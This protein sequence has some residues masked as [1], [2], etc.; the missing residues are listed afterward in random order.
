MGRYGSYATQT[1]AFC[2]TDYEPCRDGSESCSKTCSNRLKTLRKYGVVFTSV[3]DRHL[4]LH[5][6]I[7]EADY[8]A[9]LISQGGG[10][11]ICSWRPQPGQHRLHVDHDHKNKRVRGLLCYRCNSSLA[12]ID[13]HGIDKIHGYLAGV[14]F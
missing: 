4:Y 1:C 9:M 5:Y 3:L 7:R 13:A 10:C 8:D 6:G 11:A 12:I 14:K 2:G